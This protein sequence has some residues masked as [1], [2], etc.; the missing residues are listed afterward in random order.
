MKP[1]GSRVDVRKPDIRPGGS[2]G[3]ALTRRIALLA[4][5]FL[6]VVPLVAASY[7]F[8]DD[9]IA[10]YVERVI[11]SR[12]FLARY[13]ADI[14]DLLLPA[15]LLLSM[16]MWI[17]YYRRLRRGVA[18]DRSRFFRSMGTIPP[19][20]YV[21][22]GILKYVF[23]RTN[24]RYWLTHHAADSFHWLHGGGNH[25]GFPSGHMAVFSAAAAVCWIFFPRHRL[26]YVFAGLA[27]GGS[28]VAT[29]YHFLSDVIAGWFL[30]LA[31]ASVLMWAVPGADG[32]GSGPSL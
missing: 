31:V 32:Q 20:V 14:P 3:M 17:A 19:V 2:H 22:K 25:E 24:T 13:T 28:L 21:L 1:P 12:P 15:V 11:R 10:L 9:P 18:D 6:L 8:L 7:S 30:G 23:G 29:N 27:L 26:L 16:G 4:S 5:G